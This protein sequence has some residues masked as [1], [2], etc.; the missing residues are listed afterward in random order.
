[1]ALTW[2][3]AVLVALAGI[4]A[5]LAPRP[6]V[7]AACL[8]AVCLAGLLDWAVAPS[9]RAIAARRTPGPRVRLDQPAHAWLTLRNTGRRRARLLVR[10]AWAPSAGARETRFRAVLA[11][12]EVRERRLELMPTRRGVLP[13]D[14]L[15]LRSASALGFIAR[16][17][18]FDVPASIR[19]MPPFRSR[20]Y[21][22]SKR[23]RLRELDGR[24]ALMVRGMG[25][26]FDSLR[27][28]VRGDDVRS[29]DWRATARAQKLIVRTW[30]PE[31]DR[32]V[33]I[34]IDS[35]RL[36]ARRSGAGTV[37]DAALEAAMLLAALA[38]GAGDR[39]DV[40]VADARVRARVGPLTGADP[41]G[42]LSHELAPVYPELYDADWPAIAS[43]VLATAP[44][45]ALVVLVT[46]LDTETIARDL[47]PALPVL[48]ARHT[49]TLAAPSDP[50][51][52]PMA[53]PRATPAQV[54]RAAAAEHEMLEADSLAHALGELG[55]HTVTRPPE[56]LAPALANLYIDLKASGRL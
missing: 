46:A 42:R 16:Q 14:R 37:F 51:L 22:P 30:R 40:I 6:A 24:T 36:A 56:A 45:H 34:V 4:P 31:R 47:L 29:I 28:Y 8:T 15:T 11:P 49:V 50:D 39:V 23:Q 33:V 43:A 32:R 13:A 19:V 1:M 5:M 53:G 20:R 18:S 3:F 54:Y 38:A 44:S 12:G 48:R 41:L 52:E 25:T 7:A 9:P 2:R 27:E 26:E 10:D 21:L 55:L 17:R 35:S